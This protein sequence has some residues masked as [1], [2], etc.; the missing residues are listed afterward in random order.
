MRMRR[1]GSDVVE[2][3]EAIRRS[4][5]EAARDPARVVAALTRDKAPFSESA[6]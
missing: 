2:R 6:S 5:P 3:A 4:N 1:V